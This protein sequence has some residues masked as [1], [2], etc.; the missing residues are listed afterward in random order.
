ML[1]YLEELE[2]LTND[3]AEA[4]TQFSSGNHKNTTYQASLHEMMKEYICSLLEKKRTA[5]YH[6]QKQHQLK[7]NK[8]ERDEQRKLERMSLPAISLGVIE[9]FI[10]VFW[11]C[12]RFLLEQVCEINR[13]QRVVDV[14][15]QGGSSWRVA[16]RSIF[17]SVK[18]LWDVL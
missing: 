15:S 5:R 8:R 14:S 7:K 6:L 4:K 1:K 16:I 3:P 13:R 2:N 12:S 11:L 9:I 10:N 18:K 17:H